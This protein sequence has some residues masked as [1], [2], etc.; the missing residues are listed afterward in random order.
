ML[1]NIKANGIFILNT[2]SDKDAVNMLFT[3]HD[4]QIIQERNIKLY[5]IDANH[6]SF[7]N[8]LG[9][10]INMI[11]TTAIFKVANIIPFEFAIEELK[12]SITAILNGKTNDVIEK[13][14][15]AINDAVDKITLVNIDN[16]D[17]EENIN[18]EEDLF[19]IIERKEGNSLS[20]SKLSRFVDGTF[21]VGLSKYDSKNIAENLPCYNSDNCI[22]CNKCSFVCPHG[23]IRP[24]LLDDNEFKSMPVY[25]QKYTKDI[26]I[27]DKTFKYIIGIAIDNCTGCG[28]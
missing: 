6:I 22:M 7:E 14:L 2:S 28:L 19:D 9:N 11:M 20:V 16:K 13:N 8:E 26:K 3:S 4:K 21:P 27:K 17:V 12:K 10:K 5:I 15:K 24:F 25:L 1:D 18:I 23:V